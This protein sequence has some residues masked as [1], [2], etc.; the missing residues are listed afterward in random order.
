[1]AVQGI[2]RCPPWQEQQKQNGH[3]GNTADQVTGKGKVVSLY[4]QEGETLRADVLGILQG[5]WVLP[6]F[7]FFLSRHLALCLLAS[8]ISQ[9]L[10]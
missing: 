9:N 7:L 8:F 10:L 6:L 1:M 3:P 4:I 2:T 5:Y